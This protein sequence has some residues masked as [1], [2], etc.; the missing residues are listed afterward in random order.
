[1]LTDLVFHLAE[2]GWSVQVV[3]SRQKYEDPRACLK[4]FERLK[5][6]TIRRVST[7]SF[8]RGNIIGRLVDFVSF[9]VNAFY[10][11]IRET[12]RGDI[13]VAK[14]DPPLISVIATVRW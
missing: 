3:T 9:Y 11:L 5:N 7:S 1:M 14:T 10:W 8:G 6:V 13:L 2:R 4:K 12:D